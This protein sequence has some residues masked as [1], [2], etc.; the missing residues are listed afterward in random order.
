MGV[1]QSRIRERERRQ[2]GPSYSVKQLGESGENRK[3]VGKGHAQYS[4]P[5]ECEAL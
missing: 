1:N 4:A 3:A 2:A 5:K